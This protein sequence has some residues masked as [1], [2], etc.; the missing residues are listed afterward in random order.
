MWSTAAI[1]GA[2]VT[3]PPGNVAA[4]SSASPTSARSRPLDGR[5]EVQHAR[6]LPLGHQLGPANAARLA[7]AREIV[8]FEVD[9][10]HVLG[11]DPSP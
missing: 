7:H 8:A 6:E 2:P 5:D 11:S 4:S 9:D 1:F 3:E 10:H